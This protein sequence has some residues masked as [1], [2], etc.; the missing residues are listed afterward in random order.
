MDGQ[1]WTEAVALI[2]ARRDTSEKAARS[3][4]G[5][6]L[7]THGLE[8]RDLLPALMAAKVNGTQDPKAYLS[9]TAAQIAK[10]RGSGQR[11]DVDWC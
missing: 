1:A 10:R 8:A 3:F 2:T 7:S 4:F 11:Q 5:K 9:K 6:L